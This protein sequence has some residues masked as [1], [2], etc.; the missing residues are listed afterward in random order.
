MKRRFL[1]DAG[2]TVTEL[3]V[4][5]TLMGFILAAAW[6][7][8]NVSNVISNK[9]TAKTVAANE[10]QVFLDRV[11]L[12]L[13]CAAGQFDIVGAYNMPDTYTSAYPET[14]ACAERSPLVANWSSNG[15]ALTFYTDLN[16]DGRPERVKYYVSGSSLLRVQA[17]AVAT[18]P[19][20]CTFGA[21][22]T[23]RVV[24]QTIDPAWSGR[25]FTPL[26]GDNIPP[27]P[28]SDSSK[29]GLATAVTVQIRNRQSWGDQQVIYDASTTARIRN[30]SGFG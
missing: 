19:L 7:V 2:L 29:P 13:R 22:S 5:V 23:P 25:I 11:G 6:A 14:S 17:S 9:T 28:V 15:R 16:Q 10:A 27:T 24:I 8:V 20:P 3:L 26:T 18:N 4:V 1:D 21:D 12:E 30:R